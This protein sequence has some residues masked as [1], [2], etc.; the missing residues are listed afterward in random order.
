MRIAIGAATLAPAVLAGQQADSA[1][2]ASVAAIARRQAVDDRVAAPGARS[3]LLTDGAPTPRAIVLLHGLTDSPRQFER[4][5]YMLYGDGYN[6]YVPRLP[7]HGLRGRGVRVLSA[8]TADKLRGAADSIVAEAQGLG[9]SVIVVGLSMGGTMAAWIAQERAVRR[10]VLVAPAIEPGRI[11]SML[12]RPLIG[13]ADRLP[14]I[15]R[16]SPA[17]SA[18]PDRE[19]GFDLQAAAQLFSL[20]RSVLHDAD[21]HAPKTRQMVVLVNAAD[22]TVKTSAAEALARAWARRGASV[23]VYEIPDSLRLPHNIIDPLHGRVGGDAVL[24]L[25]RALAY[26]GPPGP[27]VQAR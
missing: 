11:P 7:E 6:V 14:A 17:D 13:L 27:L 3:I 23:A 22:R 20:G 16:R 15:S 4:L 1:Y 5:A 24:T 12:D 19:P 10:V 21:R 26:G 25:L 9:D 2:R 8:L 18:R